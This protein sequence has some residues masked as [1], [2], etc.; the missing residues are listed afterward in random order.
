MKWLKMIRDHIAANLGVEPEDFGCAPFV[1][2]SGLGK[3]HQ[4]SG[5]DLA[6]IMDNLN[7]A[8]VAR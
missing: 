1:Q 5:D 7:S 2:E 8:L 4:L 6:P 3:V